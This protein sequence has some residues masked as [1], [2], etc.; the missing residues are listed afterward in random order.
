MTAG[1]RGETLHECGGSRG[2]GVSELRMDGREKVHWCGRE[3]R[4]RLFES[5][6]RLLRVNSE[7]CQVC[8]FKFEERIHW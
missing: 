1:S 2:P 4:P 8:R 3:F 7:I 6:N 5:G